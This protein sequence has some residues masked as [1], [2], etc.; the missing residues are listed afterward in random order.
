MMHRQEVIVKF[1]QRLFMEADFFRRLLANLLFFAFNHDYKNIFFSEYFWLSPRM[2]SCYLNLPA[3]K[4][5][6][7]PIFCVYEGGIQLDTE[8]VSKNHIVQHFN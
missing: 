8:A 4:K 2:T 5:E 7:S 1:F 6:D 3:L